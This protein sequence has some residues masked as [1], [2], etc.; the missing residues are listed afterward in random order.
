ME[1]LWRS[2]GAAGSQEST[3]EKASVR[4]IG[5]WDGGGTT[6]EVGTSRVPAGIAE[7]EGEPGE[8]AGAETSSSAATN[9]GGVAASAEMKSS[10][11]DCPTSDRVPVARPRPRPRPRDELTTCWRFHSLREY[12][13]A[14]STIRGG[15]I[16]APDPGGCTAN[17]RIAPVFA[18]LQSSYTQALRRRSTI[19]KKSSEA[20]VFLTAASSC[21]LPK[22]KSRAVATD[23]KSVH[24]AVLLEPLC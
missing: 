14:S 24:A 7:T 21:S 15:A 5:P 9:G 13:V 16:S 17:M 4:S 1:L 6:G 8:A 11:E 2:G 12:S 3:A 22:R 10:R 23:Q 20:N 19:S 18:P